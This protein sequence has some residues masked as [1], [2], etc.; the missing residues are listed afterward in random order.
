[1][2]VLLRPQA[3]SVASEVNESGKPRID[4][5]LERHTAN[6]ASTDPMPSVAMNE[7]MWIFTTRK[8]LMLPTMNPSS[9]A[10]PMATGTDHPASTIA[11]DTITADAEI[12]PAIDRSN[13]PAASGTSRPSATTTRIAF[14]FIT[15]RWVSHVSHVFGTHSE[16]TTQ[17]RP[18]R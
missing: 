2:T 6:A 11:H 8:P 10:E 17:I 1:M 5:L 4:R 13:T 3:N 16:N 15:D 14:W 7:S 18:Y 9:S 12:V